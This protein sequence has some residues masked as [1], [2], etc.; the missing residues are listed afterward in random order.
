M[1]INVIGVEY[2]YLVLLLVLIALY[3]EIILI[4]NNKENEKKENYS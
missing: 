1:F 4:E 3:V 2:N